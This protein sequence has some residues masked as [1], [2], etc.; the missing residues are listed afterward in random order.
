[1]ENSA[2]NIPD[3]TWLLVFWPNGL[4]GTKFGRC[5]FIGLDLRD[6]FSRSLLG[7]N[8]YFIVFW[9]FRPSFKLILHTSKWLLCNQKFWD[10]RCSRLG[11]FLCLLTGSS[12][13]A[14]IDLRAFYPQSD[15]SFLLSWLP[16]GLAQGFRKIL[17]K[18]SWLKERIFS[19][20]KQTAICTVSRRIFGKIE[21]WCDS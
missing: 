10:G 4:N 5:F 16:W 21:R 11:P 20:S 17:V 13:D 12:R 1:M 6:S 14:V 8:G 18:A 2:S 7:E 3:T 15:R 9:H 19:K